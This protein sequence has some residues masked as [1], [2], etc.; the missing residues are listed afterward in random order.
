MFEKEEVYLS[1]PSGEVR[2]AEVFRE[3]NSLSIL[4]AGHER[5]D[6]DIDSALELIETIL[7]LTGEEIE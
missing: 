6:L 1:S 2:L 5:I 7:M 3:G 4:L